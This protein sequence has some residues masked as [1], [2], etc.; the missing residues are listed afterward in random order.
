MSA[1]EREQL[2][3]TETAKILSALQDYVPEPAVKRPVPTQEEYEKARDEQDRI[4]LQIDPPRP[5]FDVTKV[6]E[7]MWQGFDLGDLT[8]GQDRAVAAGEKPGYS[9]AA[10]VLSPTAADGSV[11]APAVPPVKSQR[12]VKVVGM[13]ERMDYF[14]KRMDGTPNVASMDIEDDEKKEEESEQSEQEEVMHA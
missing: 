7:K 2:S 1:Q 5:E 3:V 14:R 12:G 10:S 11:Q 8:W 4:R 13:C 9:S 6:H